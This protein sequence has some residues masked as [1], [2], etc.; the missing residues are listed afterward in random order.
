[1][2]VIANVGMSN[3]DMF[4]TSA[5]TGYKDAVRN[6]VEGECTGACVFEKPDKDGEVVTVSAVKID[7]KIYSGNSSIMVNRVNELIDFLGDELENG[8][9]VAF[10]SM[11]CAS[12]DGVSLI[13]ID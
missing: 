6:N 11:K 9:K 2:N 1:M 7:G 3:V 12:G 5:S 10:E 13:V 4:N 8:V